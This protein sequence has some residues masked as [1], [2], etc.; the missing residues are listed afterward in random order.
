MSDAPVPQANPKAAYI[1]QRAE[2]QAAIAR[3]LPRWPPSSLQAP[4]RC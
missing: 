4:D 2:I 3:V 1:A